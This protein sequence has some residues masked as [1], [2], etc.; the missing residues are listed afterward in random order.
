M[1]TVNEKMEKFG[2]EWRKELMKLNIPTLINKFH[3][4]KL[5]GENKKDIVDKIRLRAIINS[6]ND[7]FPVGSA[8]MW[9]PSTI[10]EPVRVTVK[11]KAY[12]HHGMAVVFF[13]EVASFCSIEPQFIAS[14]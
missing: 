11:Y 5:P 1:S 7:E 4:D 13:N 12:S 8:L 3:I 6:F 2:E 14:K 9:K 10:S